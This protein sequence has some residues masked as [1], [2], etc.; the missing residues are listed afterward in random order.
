MEGGDQ[1][2]R[3]KVTPVR[4]VVSLDS[5]AMAGDGWR[6]WNTVYGPRIHE[7]KTPGERERGR[8][9]YLG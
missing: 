2:G 8:N 9:D 3:G 4:S 1:I 5:G 7:P 6:S